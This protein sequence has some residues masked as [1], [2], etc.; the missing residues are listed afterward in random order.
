MQEI[1]IQARDVYEHHVYIRNPGSTIAWSFSTKKNNISF[2]LFYCPGPPFI[3]SK[4][5]SPP[6]SSS[7]VSSKLNQSSHS[8]TQQQD[9][10]SLLSF[11]TVQTQPPRRR[12]SVATS[13]M[14]ERD[15][16]EIIPVS[17]VP[18]SD[19][20]IQGSHVA[21]EPGNFVLL[22]DNTSSIQKPKVL[23]FS[24]TSDES[25]DEHLQEDQIMA[26][27]LLK[28]RRKRM[29]GW[30]K[31]W[32]QLLPDGTL[33]YSVDPYCI[34]RGSI[35]VALTTMTIYP[36]QRTIHMDT[37]TNVYH[38][39]ALTK[40]QF[41]KWVNA[42]RKHHASRF[43]HR[44]SVPNGILVDGEW[45]LPDA[46]NRYSASLQP[47]S[48]TSQQGNDTE[49]DTSDKDLVSSGDEQEDDDQP[50]SMEVGFDMMNKD[51]ISLSQDVHQLM[52]TWTET[53]NV[54]DL[55]H[56]D[57]TLPVSPLQS[58]TST[59]SSSLHLQ[60]SPPSSA[61]SSHSQRIKRKFTFRRGSQ[62]PLSPT[63]PLETTPIHQL[64][65]EQM[66]H[67]I[68]HLQQLRASLEQDYAR[69]QLQ[70]KRQT[71]RL[72]TIYQQSSAI[73]TP[74]STSFY[75]M[76]S[77]TSQYADAQDFYEEDDV[78]SQDDGESTDRCLYD[79]PQ[80]DS[81]SDEGQ[82]ETVSKRSS[83]TI[84]LDVTM[85]HTTIQRRS[86]LPQRMD[87]SSVNY[88]GLIRK[89]VGKD[90]SSISMPVSL[91]EP[92]NLLQRLC[93]ELEYSSLLDRANG[94]ADPIDQLMY[95]AVF[96]VTAF[97]SSQYRSSKKPFNPLLFETYECVRPDRGFK[98][99]AEKVSHRPNV[100]ACHAE[101]N[102]YSFW[103]SAECS[104]TF[105]GRSMEFTSKGAAHVHLK[106][107]GHH[108]SFNKPTSHLRNM[109][110][111]GSPY[112]EHLG[113]VKVMNETTGDY[114]MITYKEGKTSVW[115]SQPKEANQITMVCYRDGKAV[116]QVEGT[117]SDELKLVHDER[118]FERLWKVHPPQI[119]EY[120]AYFGYTQYCMELNEITEIEQHQLPPTDTRLRPD[121]RCIEHGQMDLA[122]D[123][124]QRLETMQR[125]RRT[126]YEHEGKSPQPRWFSQSPNDPSDWTYK[127]GYWEARLKKQW[128]DD[129]ENLW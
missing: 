115:S 43:S 128:P 37:G 129:L 125:Q 92:L 54:Q 110:G 122:E 31:R 9:N 77:S 98:F 127:G 10:G 24:V 95:V 116:R 44:G 40:E 126:Q 16:Q 91:N 81:S 35:Q 21:S 106:S 61:S 111:V 101:S 79:D 28:K 114:A 36:K 5:T 11:T 87:E 42:L 72:S 64:K 14:L 30:A 66:Q 34:K 89:A 25:V 74:S 107:S 86:R 45:L 1:Q 103:Q 51:L 123:E 102:Q 46:K 57:L 15:F 4:I 59:N 23:S 94:F 63:E 99:I 39:K 113:S 85:A 58:P 62:A 76:S 8:L 49:E 33:S 50:N 112:L 60:Q 53:A 17:H 78:D 19:R 120:E 6:N 18:S 124:K 52:K 26:D 83:M 56:H 47:A 13:L 108:F 90:L 38:L 69:L 70:Y 118:N 32:F 75:S 93:E 104:S 109:V 73:T 96:S 2:G 7:L 88:L 121:Q 117:W 71:N 65:L 27:Y 29:Q 97:A 80:D 82:D 68:Q 20:T 22:F 100:M 67:T 48:P 41:N 12:K 105:W 3:D 55:Q 84:K 119:Q